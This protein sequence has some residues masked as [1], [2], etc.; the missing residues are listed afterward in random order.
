MGVTGRSWDGYLGRVSRTPRTRPDAPAHR[1]GVRADPVSPAV[2]VAVGPRHASETG[3][4]S[5]GRRW[6]APRNESAIGAPRRPPL[7]AQ[8]ARRMPS[9][10]AQLLA[11]AALAAASALSSA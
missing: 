11:L 1:P 9:V 5:S 8:V 2:R 7:R 6:Y 10:R 3:R 4:A